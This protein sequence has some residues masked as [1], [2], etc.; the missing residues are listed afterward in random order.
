MATD[1]DFIF[2][3]PKKKPITPIAVEPKVEEQKLKP[4]VVLEDDKI[5]VQP[6][7]ITAPKIIEP[8]PKPKAIQKPRFVSYSSF[9]FIIITELN[10]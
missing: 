5:V 1:D 6:K 2:N 7:P 10:A 9:F 3:K 8:A 4:N